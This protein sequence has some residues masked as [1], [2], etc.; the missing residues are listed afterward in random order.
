MFP[1]EIKFLSHISKWLEKTNDISFHMGNTMTSL[2]DNKR[3]FSRQVSM[4]F[5]CCL[6]YLTVYLGICKICITMK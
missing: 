2:K 6:A 5:V 1:L 4:P 3:T